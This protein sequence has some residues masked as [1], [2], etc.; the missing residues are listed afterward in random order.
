MYTR[1][2][3]SHRTSRRTRTSGDHGCIR[4]MRS[5]FSFISKRSNCPSFSP[6]YRLFYYSPS[7]IAWKLGGYHGTMRLPSKTVVALRRYASRCS[8]AHDIQ[9]IRRVDGSLIRLSVLRAIRWRACGSSEDWRPDESSSRDIAP[10]RA[11]RFKGSNIICRRKWECKLRDNEFYR[12]RSD[13]ND[14]KL[15]S[16]RRISKVDFFPKSREKARAF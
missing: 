1:R 5:E 4:R 10:I 2:N 3:C 14:R 7:S 15:S 13:K 9:R 11:L 12:K 6:S 8:W 16:A